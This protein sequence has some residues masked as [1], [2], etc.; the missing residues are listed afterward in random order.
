[1]YREN[2]GLFADMNL[3]IKIY[4]DITQVKSDRLC[5][6]KRKGLFANMNLQNKIIADTTQV[7]PDSLCTEKNKGF[8]QI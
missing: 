5:T 3:Q 2:K 7:K 1:M 8:L 6:D 4:V